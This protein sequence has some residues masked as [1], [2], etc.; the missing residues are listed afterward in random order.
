MPDMYIRNL[1]QDYAKIGNLR[2]EAT[3][4]AVY[5][6]PFKRKSRGKNFSLN[7]GEY[8][9]G[10]TFSQNKFNF[11]FLSHNV[12]HLWCA[13]AMRPNFLCNKKL[14]QNLLNY[15]DRVKVKMCYENMTI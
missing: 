5:E 13:P 1:F 12:I 14:I 6:K 8:I 4:N 10:K 7:L 11:Y 3:S 9:P 15:R 2:L